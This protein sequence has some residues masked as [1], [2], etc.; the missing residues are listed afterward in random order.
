MAAQK[1]RRTSGE[2]ISGV[3]GD[4]GGAEEAIVGDQRVVDSELRCAEVLMVGGDVGNFGEQQGL[5]GD[6]R[7]AL[8]WHGEGW[9][10]L[11]TSNGGA[12]R[13]SS[14][15]A[16]CAAISGMTKRRGLR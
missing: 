8:V 15:G 5:K 2:L 14:S 1:G 9:R 12:K 7:V 6:L 16:R 13:R 4:R 11:A 3:L 10:W